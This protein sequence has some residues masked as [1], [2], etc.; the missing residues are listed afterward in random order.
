MNGLFR[1]LLHAAA[2]LLV[3]IAA[4]TVAAQQ[5]PDKTIRFIVPYTVGGGGDTTSRIVAKKVSDVFG[6]PIVVENRGGAGGIIGTDLVAKAPADGYTWVLG[7]D[8]PFTILPHLNQVPFDPLKDFTPVSLLAMVPLTLVGNANLPAKSLQELIAY[9]KAN[10]GKLTI[11]S[12]GNGTS[13]HLAA[14]LFKA[15]AGVDILHVP[16]KGQGEAMTG[17]LAGQVDL[18]FSSV[19]AMGPHVKNGKMRA[20]AIASKERFAGNPDVPTFAEAGYPAVEI[21]AWLGLLVPAGTPPEIVSRINGEVTRTIEQPE[22]REK[23][24]KM[25]YLPVGGPS[26]TLARLIREDYERFAKL[27]KNANIKVN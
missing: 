11:G 7:S 10:P 25:G 14:E 18:V 27:M 17:V 3:A 26:D 22:V 4:H 5:F 16:Y 15:R 9:A 6:Q 2:G 21:G 13:G 8:P 20:F 1:R 12:S 19:G 24:T 23:M